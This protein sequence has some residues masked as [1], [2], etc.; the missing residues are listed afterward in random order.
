MSARVLDIEGHFLY[1]PG[2]MIVSFDDSTTHT[3]EVK[4]VRT[5]QG[6]DLGKLGEV[7]ELYKLV[8]H[9]KIEVEKALKSLGEI[10]K[11]KPRYPRWVLILAYGFASATVGPFAFGAR[12]I[13]LPLAFFLGTLVG[14]MQVVMCPKSELYSNVF[15]VT[16][17]IVTSFIARGF[18]SLRQGNLFCFSALAQSSI[19]LILPGYIVR[20]SPLLPL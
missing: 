10:M 2:C 12:L 16:A 5:I 9:G 18:G 8:V 14:F 3:T 19:A 11:R 15:E 20:K 6:I 1:M 7:H 17:S 13:D 4:I